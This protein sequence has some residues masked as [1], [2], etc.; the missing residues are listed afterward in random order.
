M[1][2]GESVQNRSMLI[3]GYLNFL[4][5]YWSNDKFNAFSNELWINGEKHS[6]WIIDTPSIETSRN[7]LEQMLNLVDWVLILF[8]VEDIS[9]FD[10]ASEWIHTNQDLIKHCT[11]F[12]WGNKKYWISAK[13]EKSSHINK[14][15]S[16]FSLEYWEISLDKLDEA[17]RI[18]NL[19]TK[20]IDKH[21]VKIWGNYTLKLK[22]IY[23]FIH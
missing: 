8:D 4:E 9:S 2:V 22:L 17:K 19:I 1:I 7:K 14:L 23:I 15:K 11:W 6:I 20:H 5:D 21:K 18:L 10:W 16:E 13:W 3:S 12:L